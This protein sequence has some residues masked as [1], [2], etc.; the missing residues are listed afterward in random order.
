MIM[1][2]WSLPLTLTL[3][4]YIHPFLFII[5]F[6]A[7]I[8]I[9]KDDRSCDSDD[10]AGPGGRG[11]RGSYISQTSRIEN[12]DSSEDQYNDKSREGSSESDTQEQ[13]TVLKLQYRKY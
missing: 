2:V 1:Q 3:S 5:W 4:L 10:G 9:L 11:R 7:I 13:V 12:E 8:H 6:I